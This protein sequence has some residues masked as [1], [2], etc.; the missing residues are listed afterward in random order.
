LT[1][2]N[3]GTG[4]VTVSQT[5]LEA[6][7]G[8]L[9]GMRFVVATT[10]GGLTAGVVYYILAIAGSSTFT[11]SATP[12]DQNVS[13]TAVTLT[14]T[15]GQSVAVTFSYVGG[16]FN[17]P[18]SGDGYPETNSTTYSIVGGNSSIYG[19]QV[20]GRVAISQT[21]VG[22]ITTSASSNTV[23]GVGTDFANTTV[24]GTGISLANGVFVGY[25]T[26]SANTTAT[27]VKLLAN[28]AIASAASSF[29]YATHEQ[30]W[31]VRQKGKTKYLVQGITSGLVGACYTANTANNALVPGTMNIVATF[32]DASTRYVQAL[33]NHVGEIFAGDGT[34]AN[35]TPVVTSFNTA[36]VANTS[37]G[38]PYP[39]VTISG[40]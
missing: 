17:S 29:V 3:A 35:S 12:I 32:S 7:Y 36:A 5:G 34:L 21:G 39:I 27:T 40:N 31:I 9:P 15:T 22:T 37:N 1:G 38:Q 14:T 2:T 11:V 26:D 20:F 24:T 23:I 10:V 28:A 18:D 13:R 16:Y 33:T 30:G 19:K 4:L 25:V 8:L 6:T